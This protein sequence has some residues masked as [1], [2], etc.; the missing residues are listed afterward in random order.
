MSNELRPLKPAAAR[1]KEEEEVTD[2]SRLDVVMNLVYGTTDSQ[3]LMDKER[4]RRADK[5]RVF[6]ALAEVPDIDKVMLNRA[7]LTVP[8]LV[9]L[10]SPAWRYLRFA[11]ENALDAAKRLARYW[12]IRYSAF[13]E[14][15]FLPLEQSGDGALNSADLEVLRTGYLIPL[16]VDRDGLTV[17]CYDRARLEGDFH[18]LDHMVSS[19]N[20]VAFYILSIVAENPMSQTVGYRTIGVIDIKTKIYACDKDMYEFVMTLVRE[21]MPVRR[22]RVDWVAKS[23]RSGKR[24]FLDEVVPQW[25]ENLKRTVVHEDFKVHAGVPK[26]QLTEDLLARGFTHSCMP[27]DVGGEYMRIYP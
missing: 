8:H 27:K 1:K 22:A 9:D 13:G 21:A 10:E 11:K 12:E 16:D 15:A 5:R 7:I 26:K 25:V 17:V 6:G 20:R 18:E 2:A 14:N 24:H 23:P 3:A 4:A 19:I